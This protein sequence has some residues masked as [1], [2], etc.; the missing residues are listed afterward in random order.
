M[1]SGALVTSLMQ[2]EQG[3]LGF[4]A[5]VNL[6]Q[7]LINDGTVWRLQGHYGRVAMSLIESGWCHPTTPN[8][9]DQDA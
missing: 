5:T 4:D 1:T 9:E 8:E 3:E 6:F 7:A 2:Y